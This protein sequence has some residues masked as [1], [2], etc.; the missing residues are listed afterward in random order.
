ML[1]FQNPGLIDPLCIT[2]MGVSVK[3][4]ENPI[5]FFGTGLKYA[6]AATLRLGG[7]ITIWR[8]QEPMSFHLSPRTIRG[9]EFQLIEMRTIGEADISARNIL[10][11]AFTTEYGKAWEPWMI[12]RELRCNALDEE[13]WSSKGRSEPREGFTTIHLECPVVEAEWSN[14]PLHFLASRPLHTIQS[15]YAGEPFHVELHPLHPVP[16]RSFY[17]GLRVCDGPPLQHFT[18]NI[19][20]Q[21]NLTEDRTVHPH[22]VLQEFGKAISMIDDEAAARKILSSQAESIEARLDVVWSGCTPSEAFL[23]AAMG[24]H[25]QKK[26]TNAH[27][28]RMIDHLLVKEGPKPYIPTAFEAQELEEAKAIAERLGFDLSKYSIAIYQ[29]LNGALGRA[30][31]GAGEIQLSRRGF[32]D[33]MTSLICTLCEEFIHLETGFSDE[34]RSLQDYLLRNMVRFGRLWLEERDRREQPGEGKEGLGK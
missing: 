17:R 5:G 34:S 16:G 6:I 20:H 28:R 1:S 15:T 7:Q 4:T 26:L 32:E 19:L 9:K 2:T 13:G 8:G 3:E 14:L 21:M 31:M 22:Y 12:L 33:G 29:D 30:N 24:L 10:P 27:A 18:V 25:R 11:L 23:H